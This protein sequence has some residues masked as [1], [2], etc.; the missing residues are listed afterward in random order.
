[1]IA[2][3]NSKGS[4]DAL[5]KQ[6]S[7]T[8]AT[9]GHEAKEDE[10]ATSIFLNASPTWSHLLPGTKGSTTKPLS[11]KE[12]KKL[13]QKTKK[14]LVN[15]QAKEAEDIP[16]DDDNLNNSVED[17]IN[18][19]KNSLDQN[20]NYK[21]DSIDNNNVDPSD[22][23]LKMYPYLKVPEVKDNIEV[24]NVISILTTIN[25]PDHPTYK[26]FN[27]AHFKSP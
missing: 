3:N 23:T 8:V 15:M 12:L 24:T 9:G 18:P 14:R 4:Q 20:D 26:L 6:I 11:K 25:V 2:I 27:P 16:G 17:L 10:S 1:M 13:R 7:D 21:D 22:I 5:V 19:V